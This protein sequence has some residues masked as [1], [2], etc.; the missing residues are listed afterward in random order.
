LLDEPSM[1][2]AP[3]V[4]ETLFDVITGINRT[5]VSIL[6]VEQNAE[7]A[8]EVAHRAYVIEGG[9]IRLSGSGK[10]LLDNPEVKA[11]YLGG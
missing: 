5:G 11:A 8:L 4:V 2:L 6:L 7:M 10:S 1:G 3:Q 9:L